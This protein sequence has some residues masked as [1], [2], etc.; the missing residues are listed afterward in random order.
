VATWPVFLDRTMHEDMGLLFGVGE[1]VSWD[2]ILVDGE[3]EG[4]PVDRLVEADVRIDERPDFALHGLLAS[5]PELAACWRGKDA[6]GSEF[7]MRAGLSVDLFNPPF[8][9]TV[10][11]LVTRIQTVRRP[12][13][14]DPRGVWN[15]VGPWQLTD[16]P[17]TARWLAR[18]PVDPASEQDLGFLVALELRSHL[19][20]PFPTR[21]TDTARAGET[22]V[23][24]SRG[25]SLKPLTP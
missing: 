4:W 16:V 19:I 2:V 10:T 23:P 22:T 1:T 24:G 14:Q 25:D 21:S 7:Q 11:G 18:R 13:T 5:T 3:A 15:P 20:Q 17:R 12:M 8:R 6:V 9:S